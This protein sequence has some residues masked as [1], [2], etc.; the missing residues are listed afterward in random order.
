MTIVYIEVGI[1]GVTKIIIIMTEIKKYTIQEAR[2]ELIEI[3]KTGQED[4]EKAHIDADFVLLGMLSEL[5][6]DDIVDLFMNIDKW[7]S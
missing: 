1:F 4:P 2:K 3:V 7:Y 5:G 6:H